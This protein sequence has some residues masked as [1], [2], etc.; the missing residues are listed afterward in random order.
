MADLASVVIC[1]W[2]N[3]PDLELAIDSALA[4]TYRPLEV[5][6]V[7]NSSDDATA[8]EVPR[9]FGDR[10]R[11]VR[12]ANRGDSGAYNTG[13]ALA[14]GEFV[15]FLDGDDFLAPT[16]IE[17][18]VAVFRSDPQADVVFGSVRYFQGP[19]GAAAWNDYDCGE[20][21]IG[22]APFLR[23][24]GR[25][26]G[27]VLAVLFRRRALERVG[28]WD[29][30]IYVSDSDYELRALVAG[31]RYRLCPGPPL[32]FK[33]VRPGQ[34]GVQHAAMLDGAEALWLKALSLLS[35]PAHLDAV[36]GNLARVRFFRAFRAEGM[37]RREALAKC[38]QARSTC[39]GAVP[40]PAY[41]AAML[42]IAIPGGRILAR[43]A[44]LRSWRRRFARLLGYVIVPH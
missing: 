19:A 8:Q 9:R 6:V 43:S 4:Q 30:A 37:T 17:K 20:G 22:I 27:A 1:A 38:R 44:R 34:M 33:R 42:V 32:S 5:I 7:D 10:V 35:E 29:E 18:Q 16:K 11:Y 2:N 40:L 21:D 31:C 28:A 24:E 26:V 15:Q 13:M 25:C 23:E 3:W 36:A 14:R 41:A 12:Q 39:P